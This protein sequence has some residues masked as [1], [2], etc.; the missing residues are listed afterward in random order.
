MKKIV[1]VG[2]LAMAFF[3]GCSQTTQPDNLNSFAQCLTE[4]WAIM[5]W[6]ENCPHCLE[7][8]KMFGDS[9]QYIDYVECTIE[10]ERCAN[11]RGVPARQFT[12][13]SVVEWRQKLE[14]L[15]TLTNCEL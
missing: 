10:Y 3:A 5:Y 7:Q 2:I 4:N 11:L 14:T 8:K 13:G 6:A 1:L 12:D 15:A 9:F